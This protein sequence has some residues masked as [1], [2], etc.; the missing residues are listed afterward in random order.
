MHN[1]GHKRI[2]HFF[3]KSLRCP[4]PARHTLRSTR[5]YSD[6]F[7]IFWKSSIS[8]TLSSLQLCMTN[9]LFRV[10]TVTYHLCDIISKSLI[11]DVTKRIVY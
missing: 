2:T 6:L 10:Q 11:I 1:L 4:L 5:S 7:E 8:I 9:T 3:N